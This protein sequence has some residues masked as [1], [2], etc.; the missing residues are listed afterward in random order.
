MDPSS[1][2]S[3]SEPEITCIRCGYSLRSLDPSGR[4]PECGA[5]IGLSTQGRLLKFADPDWLQK[6]ARGLAIILWMMLVGVVGGMVI[7]F[8]YSSTGVFLQLFQIAA[9]AV[10]FYGVWLITEPDPGTPEEEGEVNARKVVRITLIVG[11]GALAVQL[12]GSGMIIILLSAVFGLI[13][14]VGEFAKFMYFEK[15]ARRIPD[16][17]LAARAVLLR[18]GYSIATAVALLAGTLAMMTFGAAATAA[19]ATAAG[20]TP[21]G[22]APAGGGSMA[23]GAIGGCIGGLGALA[24]LV[25]GIMSIL[26]LLRLRK[27]VA[28]EAEQARVTA[29]S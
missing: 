3:S 10:G 12:L 5:P 13:G 2:N 23:V 6:V 1:S 28:H 18:W 11:M 9:A 4:C 27:A 19:G 25:F 8:L 22:G 16:D 29:A 15:L 24:L 21:G 7:G 26:F 14:V 17:Q 20:A